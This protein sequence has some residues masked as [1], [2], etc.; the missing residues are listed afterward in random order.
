M[1]SM[2]AKFTYFVLAIQLGT[3]LN[4]A[5]YAEDSKLPAIDVMG[6]INCVY[7][8]NIINF[9]KD[10]QWPGTLLTTPSMDSVVIGN[11]FDVSY[12]SISKSA[13]MLDLTKP[14]IL[15]FPQAHQ[16]SQLLFTNDGSRLY[17]C[18][19]NLG[20]K[21]FCVN[22]ITKTWEQQAV[23]P[24][25]Q[26]P[27]S[28][29]DCRLV[30]SPCGKYLFLCSNRAHSII[31]F[32]LDDATGL[33]SKTATQYIV[34]DHTAGQKQYLM[35]DFFNELKNSPKSRPDLMLDN[36]VSPLPIIFDSTGRQALVVTQNGYIHQFRINETGIPLVH[37]ACLGHTF[38]APDKS[39]AR[40]SN[41]VLTY[42]DVNREV[43]NI[44]RPL[45]VAFDSTKSSL[46]VGSFHGIY[47]LQYDFKK[48]MGLTK[49]MYVGHASPLHNSNVISAESSYYVLKYG[50]DC[51]ALVMSKNGRYLFT[52]SMNEEKVAVHE[53][54]ENQI[55]HIGY[56]SSLKQPGTN[57]FV[58]VSDLKLSSDGRYLLA[59]SASCRLVI[60]RLGDIFVD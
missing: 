59:H 28:A 18:D 51:D 19:Y 6:Q 58:K 27:P 37:E 29:K 17:L 38:P 9:P 49:K 56:I 15:G 48:K 5:I 40:D 12:F 24:L 4:T 47:W 55:K 32:T 30:I 22:R 31:V 2:I 36:F 10:K 52:A 33:F 7:Q 43:G 26:F 54:L 23:D 25:S 57:A 3:V 16:V 8:A 53:L 13:D 41:R 1:R 60:F 42:S 20:L 21:L 46:I 35:P 45:A 50:G 14:A 39:S 34:V 11:E 44:G